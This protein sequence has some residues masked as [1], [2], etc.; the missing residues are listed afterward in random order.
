[1]SIKKV[2]F[3]SLDIEEDD[4]V[5]AKR[6]KRALVEEM[7]IEAWLVWIDKKYKRIHYKT[8]LR[9]K[10]LLKEVKVDRLGSRERCLFQQVSDRLDRRRFFVASDKAIL[11]NL[12]QGLCVSQ[13]FPLEG[14][15]GVY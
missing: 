15:Y 1:M 11:R 3:V 13:I 9:C 8:Y 7:S 4:I 12:K 10:G 2:E 6:G 14:I 5:I